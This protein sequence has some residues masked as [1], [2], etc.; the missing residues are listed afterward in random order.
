MYRV[1]TYLPLAR[2]SEHTQVRRWFLHV[3]NYVC[4]SYLCQMVVT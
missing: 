3:L 1:L 2:T 4:S